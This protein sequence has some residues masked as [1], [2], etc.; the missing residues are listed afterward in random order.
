MISQPTRTSEHTLPNL[1]PKAKTKSAPR[2]T[3]QEQREPRWNRE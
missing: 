1:K 3:F 2:A